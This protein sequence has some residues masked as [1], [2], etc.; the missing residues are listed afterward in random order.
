MAIKLDVRRL[1]NDLPFPIGE[2]PEHMRFCGIK[3]VSAKA[4]YAWRDRDRITGERLAEVLYVAQ[5]CGRPI[6]LNEYIVEAQEEQ[7]DGRAAA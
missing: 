4:I 1:I 6:D 2:L 3:P 7:D 5:R